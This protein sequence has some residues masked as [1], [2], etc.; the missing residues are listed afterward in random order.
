MNKPMK[1]LFFII[2][3]LSSLSGAV[4]ADAYPALGIPLQLSTPKFNAL[5]STLTTVKGK[6]QGTVNLELQFVYTG[7]NQFSCAGDSLI[8][9]V[10]AKCSGEQ[11]GA[12]YTLSVKPV[13]DL[14]KTK[15]TL[16]GSSISAKIVSATY[17]GP[18][19]RLT[20]R[21]VSVTPQFVTSAI[22]STITLRPTTGNTGV[23]TDSTGDI[24]SGYSQLVSNIPLT[25][26]IK[27]LRNNKLVSWN[28]SSKATG[29]KLSFSGKEVNNQWEGKLSGNI[30]PAKFS[31][32]PITIPLTEHNPNAHFSGIVS[33]GDGTTSPDSATT[34][35]VILRSDR[36]N[37]GSIENGETV[38]VD[39][40][41]LDK[42]HFDGDF[43]VATG[44]P[45]TVA[46]EIDGYSSTPKLFSSI[47]PGADIPINTTLR[48]LDILSLSA[49]NASSADG[50]LQL[51]NIPPE[52]T[53]L[54]GKVFNPE[55]ETA[56]F[57]GEFIDSVG[58]MLLP[59]VFAAVQA[60][61]SQNSAVT[62][63]SEPSQ[64]KM[65]V[66]QNTWAT[67]SDVSTANDQ[68]DVPFYF[69]DEANHQWQRSENEGWLENEAGDKLTASDLDK[70]K[71]KSYLGN[72]YAVGSVEHLSYWSVSW[73]V[74]TRSCVAGRLV[75]ANGLPI[76]GAVI[77]L[78]GANYSGSTA[79][80][81]TSYT[82]RFC[83]DAMR[84]EAAGEDLNNNGEM[85]D[86]VKVNLTAF[87]EGK[88][89][90]LGTQELSAISPSCTAVGCVSSCLE[91][92]DKKLDDTTEIQSTICEIEGQVLYSGN[93]FKGTSNLNKSTPVPDLVIAA[94][95]PSAPDDLNCFNDPLR[96]QV[97]ISSSAQGALGTF[98]LKVPV[99][100]G[101]ELWA[102]SSNLNA[103]FYLGTMIT[104]GC[105]GEPLTIN[106]DFYGV[107]D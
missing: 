67:L 106:A 23:I 98:S 80:V 97:A 84:S 24:N 105:P 73:P 1:L 61:D 83:I 50:K 65:L 8:D 59:S 57:P 77:S 15:I 35:K 79:S 107:L 40:G 29:N 56:Q 2:P 85:A 41:N 36:N 12:K 68:I 90:D 81:T 34:A 100:L 9:G 71:D 60:K 64:L 49:P 45:V 21:K 55:S 17:K 87:F 99:H 93:A 69:Y 103:N 88:Y 101:T 22:D 28:L 4:F 76:S 82:G 75:N 66:P 47:A 91:L 74:N 92:G 96:C 13:S 86:K 89:Y 25:G 94:Y 31:K 43:A 19:G 6:V 78:S 30:G 27:T 53:S 46:F 95:D 51:K 58:N 38:T 20:Q 37:N 5:T 104:K 62:D 39:I 63:L 44:R 32:L 18:K 14:D 10:A 48:K 26:K 42:G 70:L 11:T 72:I 52:I 33:T 54:T 16:Q 7:N 102:A 3:L